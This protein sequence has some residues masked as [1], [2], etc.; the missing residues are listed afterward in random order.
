MHFNKDLPKFETDTILNTFN[1][2]FWNWLLLKTFSFDVKFSGSI[3]NF[4][5]VWV[6]T[7]ARKL[8]SLWTIRQIKG[9]QQLK[10]KRVTRGAYG[11][12]FLTGF[13]QVS[14]MFIKHL[15]KVCRKYLR[16]LLQV[17]K[18]LL[19]TIVWSLYLI[20]NKTLTIHDSKL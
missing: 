17:S 9:K 16:S 2:K 15:L 19:T 18:K 5:D 10:I 12:H 3:V 4:M 8:R 13:L 20:L 14:H 1:F 11:F 6:D 7:V